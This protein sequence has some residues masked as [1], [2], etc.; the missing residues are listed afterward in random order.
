[1]FLQEKKSGENFSMKSSP[2]TNRKGKL[3][4]ET[5]LVDQEAQ[6]DSTTTFSKENVRSEGKKKQ[7]G[8]SISCNSHNNNS[9]SGQNHSY[10]K[11]E[12][13]ASQKSTQFSE[14]E[15]SSTTTESSNHEDNNNFKVEN[16]KVFT[17]L[18]LYLNADLYCNKIL[19][20][21]ILFQNCDHVSKEEKSQRKPTTK[22]AKP[23]P[24]PPSSP[25]DYRDNYE[26]D[27]DDDDYDKEKQDDPNRWKT[28]TTRSSSKHLHHHHHHHH[29]QAHNNVEASLKVI[30]QSKN[31]PRKEKMVQ[32]RW[33]AEK[34]PTKS[35]HLEILRSI[36]RIFTDIYIFFS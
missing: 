12:A 30:R 11:Y 18:F 1:M 20:K 34:T 27:C 28:S 26:G 8:G 21:T 7:M 25:V 17:V 10:K 6:V 13:N 2:L 22:K 3:R 32:K 35:K 19:T 4:E 16:R 14:E 9:N 23:Q 33:V 31:P 24:V 5:K 36:F 15:T 29:H